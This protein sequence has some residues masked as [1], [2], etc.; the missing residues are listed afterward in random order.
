VVGVE[1]V[2]ERRLEEEFEREAE[3]V[4]GGVREAV[5]NAVRLACEPAGPD[6]VW[7]TRFT[8]VYERAHA[9]V[10]VNDAKLFFKPRSARRLLPVLLRLGDVGI[11]DEDGVE[12]YVVVRRER[13]RKQLEEELNRLIEVERYL[14]NKEQ[15]G[16]VAG[17]LRYL[18]PR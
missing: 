16:A 6:A 15:I 11:V 12:P 9:Y 7:K 1:Y 4:D 5:L 3:S 13:V 2:Y 8:V 18:A 10:Y 17:A 14:V